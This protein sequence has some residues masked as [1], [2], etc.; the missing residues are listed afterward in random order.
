MQPAYL[1]WLGYFHRVSLSDL[2]IVLDHVQVD[3]NSKTGFAQRNKVRTR[4]GWCWLS[5]P[6]KTKGR[7]GDLAL[8]KVEIADDQ[9]WAEKH[10]STLKHCYGKAPFFAQHA[11]AVE[12]WYLRPWNCL[13][14]LAREV[15][16]HHLDALDLRVPVRFSSEMNAR[17]SKDELIRELC[18]EVGATVYVSGPFGRDYLCAEAFAAAGIRLVFHEYVHPTYRQAYPGF[19]PYMAALDL[20]FNQGPESLR[21]I[22]TGNE[23]IE[24][25]LR[26]ECKPEERA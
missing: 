18:Q 6:L 25:D 4:D 8:N 20:L 23:T 1:P 16:R 5:V 7:S 17:S 19:E 14:E 13:A 24:A 10:W 3:R 26:P 9:N 11:A 2:F 21:I 12:A 22:R 15:I